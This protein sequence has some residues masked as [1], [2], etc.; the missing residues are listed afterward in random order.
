MGHIIKLD[1]RSPEWHAFRKDKIGSSDAASIMGVS[2]WCTPWQCYM[3]KLG[4]IPEQADNFAMEGGRARESIALAAFNEKHGC[5]CVPVVMQ[6]DEYPWMIASLDG[7]D[8]ERE[9]AVEIKCP[10]KEDHQ[11][12]HLLFTPPHYKPQLQHQLCVMNIHAMYYWSWGKDDVIVLGVE[13][14]DEYIKD[15]IVKE[16]EFILRMKLLDP[17]PISEKDYVENHSREWR[18]AVRNYLE[19]EEEKERCERWYEDARQELI[20][21]AGD[22]NCR[23]S[24]IQLTKVVRRGNVDYKRAIEELHLDEEEFNKFRKDPVTSW[25]VTEQ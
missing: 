6:H 8:K 19:C 2:K 22:H 23:G 1:Q 11:I 16:Q 21:L 13:R 20:R 24:G 7:W 4:L 10:G 15:M 5:N 14:D 12:A 17:P 3:R 25:R 9:I 18:Y